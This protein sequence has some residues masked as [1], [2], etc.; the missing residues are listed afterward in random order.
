ML[1]PAHGDV[2]DQ[3]M[4]PSALTLDRRRRRGVAF[5]KSF[6]R[7]TKQRLKDP[8]QYA[9]LAK[10]QAESN[11]SKPWSQLSE[12]LFLT[13]NTYVLVSKDDSRAWSSIRGTRTARSRS[14]KLKAD[15]KLGPAGSGA[16]QPRPLRPLRRHLHRCSTARSREVWTLDR[17]AV[18][19]ADPFLLRPPFLDARPVKIDRRFKDGETADMA[20]VPPALPPPAGPD[21]VHD[22][23]GD[24]DRRQALLLHGRQL[25]PPGPVQ[26]HRRLDG[27]EPE[28]AAALCRQRPE[29]AGRRAGL[30]AGRARRRL[31]VQRRG[32]PPPRRVGQGQCAKAADV[33][34]RQR[35]PSPSTGT[36]TASTSSRW[37][38]RRS[39]ARR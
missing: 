39:P 15:Q 17:V 14:P 3:A 24:G 12:H 16:V 6:E 11:G 9:F 2:I 22:G 18:P 1:L 8:P 5:L 19:L 4:P 33:A 10:E 29:G 28:L 38:R 32:L 27:P 20:R 13:G 25:L 34:V 7:Y 23:R 35:Q 36:R 31:R 30:G 37:C 21:R 26:R